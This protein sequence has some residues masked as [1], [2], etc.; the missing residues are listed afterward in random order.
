MSLPWPNSPLSIALKKLRKMV[1]SSAAFLTRSGETTYSLD[2][3][4]RRVWTEYIPNRDEL[5]RETGNEFAINPTMPWAA[6]WPMNTGSQAVAC[7][8]Q[9]QTLPN[10]LI[11]LYVA[12]QPL[13][14][15]TD[16]NDRREEAVGFLDQWIC[17]VMNLSGADDSTSDD[18]MGHLTIVRD[19]SV[20]IDH[21]PFKDRQTIGDFYYQSVSLKYGDE[22]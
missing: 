18:G 6:I 20:T 1:A 21:V 3:S 14:T 16:W 4:K 10:G 13:A 11:H 17:D 5:I 9:V 12:C 19:E 7:G 8:A 22:A 15:L 2:M